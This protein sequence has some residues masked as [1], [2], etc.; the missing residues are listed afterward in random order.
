[1]ATAYQIQR[2]LSK[3]LVLKRQ[4]DFKPRYVAGIDSSYIKGG[5][6]IFAAVVV[7]G[8]PHLRV[9]E[10]RSAVRRVDFPYIPGL[11]AFREGPAVLDAI[12]KVESPLDVILIDGQGIAHQRGMG[13]ASHIGVLLDMPSVGCAKTKLVGNFDPPEDRPGATS[14]LIYGGKVVGAVL[15]TKKGVAPVFVSCG[16]KIDLEG[17]VELVMAC[18]KGY[19][20][21]EPIRLADNLINRPPTPSPEQPKLF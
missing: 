14:P 9:V 20:L 15:R 5:N 13:I 12:E 7:M 8:L 19:R 17:A 3:R 16:H 10:E 11:L 21:P 6:E 18:L 2:D 4:A 1:M